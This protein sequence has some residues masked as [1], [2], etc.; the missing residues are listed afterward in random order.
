MA[1]ERSHPARSR[2]HLQHL[3]QDLVLQL[4]QRLGTMAV[5]SA[6]RAARPVRPA[7]TGASVRMLWYRT[8]SAI[9]SST[10]SAS[11]SPVTTGTTIAS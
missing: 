11:T 1:Q 2:D 8:D 9:R 7:G 4:G 6:R 3:A 10:A 5:C